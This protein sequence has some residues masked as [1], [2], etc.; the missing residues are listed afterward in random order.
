MTM[1]RHDLNL[2]PILD[3]LLRNRNVTRAGQEL[4]LSQSAT[5]HALNRLR[6]HFNDRLLIPSGNELLPT[7]R[8]D[9][10]M[11]S[12]AEILQLIDRLLETSDFDPAQALRRFR[13]G[14]SDYVACLLL[15]SL[16]PDVLRC[17]PGVT[18]QMTWDYDNTAA[19]LQ[20]GQLD[21][22]LIPRGNIDQ[23]NLRFETFYVD[24]LV[25]V[26]SKNHQGI[27]DKIDLDTFLRLP[28]AGFRR[29]SASEKSFAD[30]Q[31]AQNNLQVRETLWVSD[32]LPL[33]FTI[34]NTECVSLVPRR[35]ATMLGEVV[36]LRIFDVP[37]A[38]EPL[39]VQAYWSHEAHGDPGHAWLRQMVRTA[40][41]KS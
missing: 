13:I 19:K 33:A 6:E 18:I 5:S 12:L 35:V 29:E 7:H 27:G 36:G 39:H 40:W 16:V 24:E 23:S 22:A 30:R 20:S 25:V 2:I 38:A 17:A 28:Y 21:L 37:F 1:R 32:F 34:A 4:G 9:A 26:A 41:A 31:L 15:P 8:A 10:M 14:T 11:G 3:A